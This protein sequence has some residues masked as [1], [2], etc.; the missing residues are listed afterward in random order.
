MLP[1]NKKRARV[2]EG[3]K[4]RRLTNRAP[5]MLNRRLL[6]SFAGNGIDPSTGWGTIDGTKMSKALEKI[7]YPNSSYN[8]VVNT[9]LDRP[10]LSVRP[11]PLHQLG[12]LV[13]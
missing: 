1:E 6:F 9:A 13:A 8:T 5:I 3:Y 12:Q 7:L 2:L 4:S 10:K 11:V